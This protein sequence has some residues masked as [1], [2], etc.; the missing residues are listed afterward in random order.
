M[1]RRTGILYIDGALGGGGQ[2]T[3]TGPDNRP[4]F[5]G[6]DGVLFTPCMPQELAGEFPT[7]T[8]S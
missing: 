5:K 4:L 2:W 3:P 7:V 8:G 1:N 6:I